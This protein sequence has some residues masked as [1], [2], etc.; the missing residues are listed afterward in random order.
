MGIALFLFLFIYFYIY[1]MSYT[2][3]RSCW[4]DITVLD[5]Q[6]SIEDKTVTTKDNFYMELEREFDQLVKYKS[7]L[8]ISMPKGSVKI[9]SN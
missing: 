8:K 7:F 1:R 2:M 9:F 4:C 6:A 3:Q 5:L